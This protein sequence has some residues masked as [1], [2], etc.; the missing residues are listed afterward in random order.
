MIRVAWSL[1]GAWLA[2]ASHDHSVS[3]H[4][5]AAGGDGGG[6]GSAHLVP[7][8][9]VMFPGCVEAAAWLDATRLAVSVRGTCMLQVIEQRHG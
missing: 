4:A 9:R 8:G 7:H 6:G 3:L 2:A 5:F 1:D